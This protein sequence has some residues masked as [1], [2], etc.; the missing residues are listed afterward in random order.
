[1]IFDLTILT[2]GECFLYMEA[3]DINV[4]I[5]FPDEEKFYKATKAK[6]KNRQNENSLDE[7]LEI[8]TVSN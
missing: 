3:K 6:N 5:K 1:M 2:A 7:V 4:T 8:I